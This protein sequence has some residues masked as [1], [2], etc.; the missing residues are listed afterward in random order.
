MLVTDNSQTQTGKKWEATSRANMSKQRTTAPHNQNQ[1]SAERKIQVVK[2]RTDQALRISCTP[3]V[4]WC[5][6][7]Y[8]I[9]DCL[10]HSSTESIGWR[11][12]MELLHGDT[13]DISMF[14][15]EFWQP[16][17]VYDNP[18]PFPKPKLIDARFIGIAWHHGDAL[19]Y[20]VWTEP[21]GDWSLN[22]QSVTTLT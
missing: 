5:Y 7:L 15:F 18:A 6:C 21:D 17:E 11:S 19:T 13:P 4:F 12:P 8:F 2:S 9:V 1:N 3:L 16:V 14:R 10:N 20:K 22:G